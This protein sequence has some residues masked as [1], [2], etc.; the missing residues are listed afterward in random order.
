MA[1]PNIT[2]IP[3]PRVEFIDPRT[4]LMAR[5]WFRFFVNLYTLTGSG[6][7]TISLTDLQVAPLTADITPLQTELQA[8]ASGPSTEW[9]NAA[10]DKVRADVQALAVAPPQPEFKHLNYASFHDTTTQTVAVINTAYPVTFNSTDLSLGVAIG[11]PTSRII[12]YDSATYQ[13]QFT[14][15]VHK[16]TAAVGHIY[17][18]ARVNGVDITST[19]VKISV[20]GATAEATTSGSFMA[21][22]APNDY[23]ELVWSSDSLAC[24]LLAAPAV[25]PVPD[26]PSVILTVLQVSI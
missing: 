5:E 17:I 14:L 23:F 21:T 1:N 15:Q 3:A 26:I 18:W 11:T 9:L 25:A 12:C 22:M 10:M 8:L 20:Q 16:T 13:F 7:S 2:Q 6:T 24:Q 19:A 4:G